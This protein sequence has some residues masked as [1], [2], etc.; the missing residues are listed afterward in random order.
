MITYKTWDGPASLL[1]AIGTIFSLLSRWQLN[2]KNNRLIILGA[3]TIWT[4]YEVFYWSPVAFAADFLAALS[5]LIAIYRFD[6][7]KEKIKI[8]T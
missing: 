2:P 7:K 6:L 5:V 8:K 1:V 4:I 3:C